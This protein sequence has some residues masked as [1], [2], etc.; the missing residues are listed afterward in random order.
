MPFVAE[1]I[2]SMLNFVVS[3]GNED[4]HV[5]DDKELEKAVIGG[6]NKAKKMMAIRGKIR[7][8]GKM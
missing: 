4:A 8:V 7:M 2:A 3:K 6:N 5:A 1:K